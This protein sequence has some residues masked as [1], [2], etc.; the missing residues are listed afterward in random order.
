MNSL[1]KISLS[2]ISIFLN[3]IFGVYANNLSVREK[4]PLKFNYII[5]K[6]KGSFTREVPFKK[7]IKGTKININNN[8]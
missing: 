7:E 6:Y 1:T 3:Y 8:I 4:D 2:I 5:R